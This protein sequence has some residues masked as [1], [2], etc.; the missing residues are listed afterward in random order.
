MFTFKYPY[1]VLHV[2]LG[3]SKQAADMFENDVQ[4]QMSMRDDA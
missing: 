3:T 2:D 1:K 4:N